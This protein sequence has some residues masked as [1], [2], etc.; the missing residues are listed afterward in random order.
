MNAPSRGWYVVALVLAVTGIACGAH[1]GL[2]AWDAFRDMPRAVMPGHA[3]VDLAAG[4]YTVFAETGGA[5]N[6]VLYTVDVE[7]LYCKLVAADGTVAD[8]APANATSSYSLGAV[9]G[10]A[11]LTAEV[12]VT[13]TYD[14]VCEGEAVDPVVLAFGDGV[15]GG[16][17]VAV[18]AVLAGFTAGLGLAA[19]VYFR[20][21]G[22]RFD[23]VAVTAQL[24][25]L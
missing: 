20:R 3:K 10:E 21:R 23:A 15:L 5:V 19:L 17:F 9:Q 24:G 7:S 13:A 2:A 18:L 11:F 6:G 1:R 12:P 8:L 25:T 4:E 22:A 16:F 14:L